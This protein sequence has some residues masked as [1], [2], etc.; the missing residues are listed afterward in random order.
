MIVCLRWFWLCGL[1]G[2][3]GEAVDLL[4]KHL[5]HNHDL[6][7][8]KLEKEL[9]DCLWYIAQIANKFG[10]TLENIVNVNLIKLKER[11]PEGFTEHASRYRK[12]SD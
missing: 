12:Q 7:L 4:K 6:D 8:N 5:G 9:G 2:E 10:L 11:Y 3:A 1:A